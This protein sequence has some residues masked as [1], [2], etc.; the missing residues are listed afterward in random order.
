[1][2]RLAKRD[3]RAD[4]APDAELPDDTRLWAALGHRKA[5]EFGLVAC[6]T[7]IRS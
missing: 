5:V 7:W 3:F 6:M 4:L 1:M 2:R